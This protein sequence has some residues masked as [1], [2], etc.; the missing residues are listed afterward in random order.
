VGPGDL[1]A[2]NHGQPNWGDFMQPEIELAYLGIAVPEPASLDTFFSDVIGL[3]PGEP[4]P[5]EVLT[6]RNDD[7]AHRIIVQQGAANDAVFLGF[8]ATG[9]R[10]LG[11]CARAIARRRL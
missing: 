9:D 1:T 7:K 6:W 11:A 2:V 4:A 10:R 3:I 8:E 5:G